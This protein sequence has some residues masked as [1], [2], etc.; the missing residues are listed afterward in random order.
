MFAFKMQT[1][2]K[3]A[4]YE[5]NKEEKGRMAFA[6]VLFLKEECDG[7]GTCEKEMSGWN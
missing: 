3:K 7:C 1:G 6:C 4:K 2:E 5:R